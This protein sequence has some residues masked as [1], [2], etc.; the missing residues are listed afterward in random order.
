LDGSTLTH[1]RQFTKETRLKTITKIIKERPGAGRL[2]RHVEHD[3][4]SRA[5]SAGTAAIKTVS[6]K[7]HGKAFDQGDLGSCTG[8]AM[9]GVLMSEPLWVS[10]RN[11]SESD[12]VALYKAATKLDSLPG[13]YAPTDT[14]SSGLAVMKA[15]VKAKYIT[16]YAHTFSLD[17]L[18]G[19]LVL[20]P[21]V[22]GINWYS[23]F[24]DPKPDGECR[25]TASAKIRGGHEVQ[26][27]GIDAA[28]ERVWC[29]NSWGPTWGGKKNGTFYF[30]W[31]TL[32][33][34][35]AEQGDATFPR[36]G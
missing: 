24:D 3:P 18:L 9:A 10:G 22:L 1:P 29:I 26:L 33:R 14:G 19:S 13:K 25:L 35:L 20:K 11:L 28:K 30:T 8:N 2:G 32:K 17:H 12:A 16:G 21:G 4:Q 31:K 6:H 34:L 7:R 5:F 27:F 15:A 23:S 36:V